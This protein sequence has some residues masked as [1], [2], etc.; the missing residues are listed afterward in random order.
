LLAETPFIGSI[1]YSTS[2][3]LISNRLVVIVTRATAAPRALAHGW[4]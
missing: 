2:V 4:E 3:L 1:T